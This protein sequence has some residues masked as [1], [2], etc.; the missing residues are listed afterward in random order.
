MN[1]LL[2][3]GWMSTDLNS[4]CNYSDRSCSSA[5]E[6]DQAPAGFARDEANAIGFP[7]GDALQPLPPDGRTGSLLLP[8]VWAAATGLQSGAGFRERR[9]NALE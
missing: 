7:Y 3:H 4:R 9:T 6:L 5:L 2:I 1:R 8:D